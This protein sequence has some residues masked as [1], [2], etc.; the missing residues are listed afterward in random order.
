MA[1]IWVRSKVLP[2]Q[3]FEL[4]QV[5]PG[6]WVQTGTEGTNSGSMS[7]SDVLTNQTLRSWSRTA[8][9]KTLKKSG[10]YIPPQ[11]FDY[12]RAEWRGQVSGSVKWYY[13]EPSSDP[14][15]IRTLVRSGSAALRSDMPFISASYNPPSILDDSVVL[16]LVRERM[17]AARWQAPVAFIEAAKTEK[18]IA[19][20]VV[21]L[22]SAARQLR[23][24]SLSG[25]LNSLDLPS[26][27]NSRTSRFN[28]DFGRDARKTAG[29][30]WLEYQYGWLPTLSDAK[31]AAELLART[32]M[33]ERNRRSRISVPAGRESRFVVQDSAHFTPYDQASFERVTTHR[34]MKRLTGHYVVDSDV[35]NTASLLSLTNPLEVA[36]ELIPFSFVADWFVPIGD[37]LSNMSALQGIT[38]K[39]YSIGT[40]V[41]YRFTCQAF[42][43]PVSPPYSSSVSGSG[44]YYLLKVNRRVFTGNPPNAFPPMADF[45]SVFESGT[46]LAS[47]VALLSQQLSHFRR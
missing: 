14:L 11:P 29:N 15:Q 34:E 27:T 8:G 9:Y 38:F 33:L 32:V 17:R 31:S 20:R 13:E 5:L 35:L 45:S 39:H 47:A 44:S 19:N 30:T 16:S 18:M 37:F 26:P 24:G 46:R 6:W 41:D 40:R 7:Y 36:W 42:S 3:A 21:G 23:R 25:F 10:A 22:V 4:R 12:S 1:V 2:S 43:M 28:R